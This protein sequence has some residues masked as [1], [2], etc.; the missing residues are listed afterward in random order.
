M[1]PADVRWTYKLGHVY[2]EL[3]TWK[4]KYNPSNQFDSKLFSDDL[5]KS[6]NELYGV[7]RQML[8]DAA[9]IEGV[10]QLDDRVKALDY[11]FSVRFS[12]YAFDGEPFWIRIYLSQD[13]T[14]QN[15][16]IDLITEVY[17]FSQKPEDASGKLACSNCK[18]NQKMDI[19]TTANIA[20]TPVLISVIKSGKDLA[21]LSKDE[22]LEFLKKRVYWRVFK[23][24]QEVPRYALDPLNLEIIG[25]SNDTTQF[26]D[27]TKAPILE[28]FQEEPAISGG[29]DGAFDPSLKQP[30]TTP[31][32]MK[33]EL[34]KANL[35]INSSLDFKNTLK[36]DS[37]I[38]LDSSNLDLT[39][40]KTSGIDNTQFWLS[41][42]KG[43]AGNILFLLSIRRA[44]KQI[45]F[46]TC[47]DNS[48][49]KEVRVSL[50]GKFK[51]STP[52][53]L[54]HDQGDGY[55]IFIDWRHVV[56]FE[57]RA[58]DRTTSSVSYTVNEGSGSVW[59]NVLKVRVFK[60]MK[61]VF[62]S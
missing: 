53:F 49:G 59:S 23:N 45:V 18:T 58:K 16:L 41:D 54:I 51:G 12:K 24:G 31:P 55:E 6:I 42:A 11:A 43:G 4:E 9:Q 34:D 28:N 10:E 17:N 36:D 1:K 19:R 37:V 26:H 50:D 32:P 56:F 27:S 29:A 35:H 46:N 25:S 7:S 15:P 3:Q 33:P 38:I 22:V 5:H 14:N 60:S 39:P 61:E 48:W 21:S 20:I 57:K 52:S 47:I 44:E 2:P 62:L 30:M 8:L 40:S 13:G